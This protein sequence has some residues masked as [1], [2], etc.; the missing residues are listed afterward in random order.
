MQ[1][2]KQQQID[3]TWDFSTYLFSFR[4]QVRLVTIILKRWRVI[5]VTKIL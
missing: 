3:Y 5:L 1:Y 4:W 2:K